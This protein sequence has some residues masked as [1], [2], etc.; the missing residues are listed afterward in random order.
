MKTI[1]PTNHCSATTTA[2]FSL[3]TRLL[4]PAHSEFFLITGIWGS[5]GGYG[6]VSFIRQLLGPQ[7]AEQK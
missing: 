4:S 7:V 3:K 6:C 5:A 2:V 1:L